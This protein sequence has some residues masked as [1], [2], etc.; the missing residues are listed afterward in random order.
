MQPWALNHSF[1]N[2]QLSLLIVKVTQKNLSEEM[3]ALSGMGA[4]LRV[5]TWR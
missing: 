1:E 3:R 2:T 4:E 5:G